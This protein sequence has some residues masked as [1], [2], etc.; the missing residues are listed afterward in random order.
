M[1]GCVY[2]VGGEFDDIN[3]LSSV[4]RYHSELDTWEEVAPMTTSRRSL[5][6]AVLSGC[7]YAVGG[8]DCKCI[9]GGTV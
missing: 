7:L 2:A 6:V 3:Y 5:G 4:E 8:D 9:F 1:D